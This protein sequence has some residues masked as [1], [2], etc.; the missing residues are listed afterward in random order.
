M[1]PLNQDEICYLHSLQ[2]DNDSVEDSGDS[3]ELLSQ[4]F[5]ESIAETCLQ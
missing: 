4:H 2:E 1:V 3:H 5:D